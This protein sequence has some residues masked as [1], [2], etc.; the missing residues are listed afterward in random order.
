MYGGMVNIKPKLGNVLSPSPGVVGVPSGNRSDSGATGLGVPLVEDRRRVRR[1]SILL[2]G[3]DTYCRP[4]GK[5]F[6]GAM[7]KSSMITA[8]SFLDNDDLY[9]SCLV[10]KGWVKLAMDDALW[11]D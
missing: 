7:N 5:H 10:S 2:Q 9:N 3:L 4:F 11:E 8:L 1:S 6:T